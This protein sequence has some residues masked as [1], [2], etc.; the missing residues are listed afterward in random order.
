[1]NFSK[2]KVELPNE[3]RM[4]FSTIYTLNTGDNFTNDIIT[5]APYGGIVLKY[6]GPKG[7]SDDLDYKGE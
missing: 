4:L 7:Q 2:R 5:L 1:M 3:V 6:Q